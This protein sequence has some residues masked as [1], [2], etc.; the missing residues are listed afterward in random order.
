MVFSWLPIVSLKHCLSLTACKLILLDSE[1]ADILEPIVSDFKAAFLV[2]ESHEGKGRWN[3]M[4]SYDGV[5]SQYP[6]DGLWILQEELTID[7]EDN[8]T[9]IFTSGTTGLPS[10]LLVF[11]RIEFLI[12]F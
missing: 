9:V 5:L 11:T 2:L 4:E 10:E 7:P 1:R 12:W 3:L 6:G 8:A